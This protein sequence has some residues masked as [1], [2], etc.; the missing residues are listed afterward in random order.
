L[1]RVTTLLST[2]APLLDID[3]Q[4]AERIADRW[5]FGDQFFGIQQSTTNDGWPCG[6]NPTTVL[7]IPVIEPEVGV[8]LASTIEIAGCWAC[9][10]RF[11]AI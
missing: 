10:D 1:L 3:I 8:V 2:I 11:V 7:F 6:N 4:L 5:I 9:K